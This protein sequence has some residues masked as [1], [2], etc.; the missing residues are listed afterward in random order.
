LVFL[1]WFGGSSSVNGKVANDGL[2]KKKK[3]R[4]D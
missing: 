2:K 1:G 3:N 4:E